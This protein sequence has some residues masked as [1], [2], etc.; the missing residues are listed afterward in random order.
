MFFLFSVAILH[1]FMSI[2]RTLDLSIK[3]CTCTYLYFKPVHCTTNRNLLVQIANVLWQPET[4]HTS[5]TKGMKSCHSILKLS[6]VG[7]R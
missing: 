7:R 2:T 4:C 5:K 3:M 1:Y 6:Q